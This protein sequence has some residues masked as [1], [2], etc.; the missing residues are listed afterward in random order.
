MAGR[1]VLKKIYH[2]A[3]SE[4]LKHSFRYLVNS[5]D[6]DAVLPAALSKDLITDRQRTE[7]ANESNPYKKAET[8]LECVQRAVNGNPHKFNDFLDILQST[9][10]KE[11]VSNLRGTSVWLCSS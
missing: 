2:G 8:F 9:S 5:I 10:Q 6:T 7:C 4:A 3:E 1:V 11:I